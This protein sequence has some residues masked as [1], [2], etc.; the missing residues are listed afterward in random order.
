MVT[1]MLLNLKKKNAVEESSIY[2]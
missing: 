1:I 2:Y